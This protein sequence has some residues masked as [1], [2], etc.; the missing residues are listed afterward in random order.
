MKII[1]ENFIE[2]E[3]VTIEINN[4]IITRKV[5]YSKEAGDLYILYKNNKYFYSEFLDK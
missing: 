5:Y 2:N 3:Y 4:N 1:K